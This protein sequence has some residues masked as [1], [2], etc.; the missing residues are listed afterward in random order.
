MKRMEL[1][2]PFIGSGNHRNIGWTLFAGIEQ[3]PTIQGKPINMRKL[4]QD[5]Q[6]QSPPT[7]LAILGL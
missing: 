1:M 2:Y 5:K 6:M 4:K 3:V 7:L